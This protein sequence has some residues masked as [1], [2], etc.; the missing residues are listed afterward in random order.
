MNIVDFERILTDFE[1][2]SV[3]YKRAILD[4]ENES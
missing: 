3:M 2:A 1:W 4:Y